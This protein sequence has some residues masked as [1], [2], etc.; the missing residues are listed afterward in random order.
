MIRLTRRNSHGSIL[1]NYKNIERIECIG[2]A[3]VVVALASKLGEYEDIGT[4]E[5]FIKLKDKIY[6]IK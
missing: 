4:V 5:E 2:N 3:D 6:I 1:V